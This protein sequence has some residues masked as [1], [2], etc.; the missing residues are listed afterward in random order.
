MAASKQVKMEEEDGAKEKEDVDSKEGHHSHQFRVKFPNDNVEYTVYCNQACTVLEAI[1]SE[2]NT[3]FM[4]MMMKKKNCTNNNLIIQ[5]DEVIVATHFPCSCIVK[6]ACL[7]I[8]CKPEEVEEARD[9]DKVL[10]RDK[11]S[12]FCISK[13][14]G[15]FAKT[16]KL[17]KSNTVK[18]F[19]YLCVYAKKGITVKEALKEDGRFLD[20]QDFELS[21]IE[22][23]KKRTL[24]TQNIDDLDGKKFKICL[25]QTPSRANR[26]ANS[27]Q[28]VQQKQPSASEKSQQNAESVLHRAQQSEISVRR[29]M[30]STFNGEVSEWFK[31]LEEWVTSDSFATMLELRKEDFGK[32]QQ[33]FSEID[34]LKMLIEMGESVCLVKINV[35]G[36]ENEGTGFVLYD[37]FVLT[38]AHLFKVCAGL[39][40]DRWKDDVKITVVFNYEKTNCESKKELKANVWDGNDALDYAIL[41]LDIE[42]H[43]SNQTTEETE[44]PPGLLSNFG[45]SPGDGE[46]CL[47]GHPNGGVKKLDPTCI[48]P[49][50]K[51]EESVNQNLEGYSD[52]IL[53]LC[54][55]N[56]EIKKCPNACVTYNTFMFHGASGSPVFDGHGRVFGLHSGGYFYDFIKPNQSVIEFA[57]PLL[58]IFRDFMYKLRESSNRKQLERIEEEA[59]GNPYLQQILEERIPNIGIEY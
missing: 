38:N 36:A 12:V 7:I 10:S 48:I 57:Q 22:D 11:Y 43:S 16:R 58:T 49:K 28:Q 21:K 34:R 6:D 27:K 59:K 40:R 3:P 26:Q 25:Y 23:S 24:C 46:A 17:F 31:H 56:Q 20:L 51:R 29:P 41:E 42:K 19:S 18:H 53:T 5:M 8:H 39:K 2:L 14:G 4:M 37:N 52:Y 9:H 13:D 30:E 1:T 47:I 44:V 55:I 35:F 50:E 32:V 45:P 33:S 15:Q 54:S